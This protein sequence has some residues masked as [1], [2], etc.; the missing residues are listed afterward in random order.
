MPVGAVPLFRHFQ[1]GDTR[2]ETEESSEK[3]SLRIAFKIRHTPSHSE[4]YVDL[5][6][7]S[8]DA[9]LSVEDWKGNL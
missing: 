9:S 7:P 3:L 6:C 8:A 1:S 2:R 4:K 5:Y